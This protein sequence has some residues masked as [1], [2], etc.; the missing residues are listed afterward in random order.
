MEVT[1][2]PQ[3][4]VLEECRFVK[5]QDC[6][7]LH[8]AIL[9]AACGIA[10]GAHKLTPAAPLRT[11]GEPPERLWIE[12]RS[13]H[14][15]AIKP[16][17]YLETVEYV[18]ADLPRAT[19]ADAERERIIAMADALEYELPNYEQM[20]GVE[21]LRKKLQ[22]EPPRATEGELTVEASLGEL[23]KSYTDPCVGDCDHSQC[24]LL[25]ELHALRIK[26]TLE[27][28]RLSVKPIVERER[29][30][31]EIGDLMDM[32]LRAAAPSRKLT[33][34]ELNHLLFLLE[35]ERE[36]GSYYGPREQHH[37]RARRLTAWCQQLIEERGQQ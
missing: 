36:S 29:K 34:P 9:C 10:Y 30:S 16:E 5:P 19:A 32:R 11:L 20:K 14:A 12:L 21:T 35:A 25:R 13:Q 27:K 6:E 3:A 28:A 23:L 1:D 22:A 7:E 8:R 17:P 26:A 31:E 18:R 2:S 24:P 4:Q 15:F 33:A 37:A